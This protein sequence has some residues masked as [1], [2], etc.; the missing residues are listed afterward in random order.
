MKKNVYGN[1]EE[2][3]VS[4]RLVSPMGELKREGLHPRQSTGPDLNHIVLGSEGRFHL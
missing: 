4:V 1:I 2:L 3:V